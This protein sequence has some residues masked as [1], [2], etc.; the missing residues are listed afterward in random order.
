MKWFYEL[1]V[2]CCNMLFMNLSNISDLKVKSNL[3][4]KINIIFQNN[5][6]AKTMKK[7]KL[8]IEDLSGEKSVEEF[9]LGAD[10]RR[11]T[12]AI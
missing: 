9:S 7:Y 6:G 12:I 4:E 3:D 8:T 5:Y 2:V 1:V 11:K 10:S